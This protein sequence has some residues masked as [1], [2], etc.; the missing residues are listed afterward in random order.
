VRIGKHTHIPALMVLLLGVVTSGLHAQE[1]NSLYSYA[2]KIRGGLT[3]GDI[4]TTHFDNKVLALAAEVRREMFGPGRAL[5]L[6]LGWE[7]VPGRHHDIYPWGENPWGLTP[8]YSFDNRKEYGNGFTLRLA[9]NAPLPEF[10]SSAV[11]DVLKDIEWFGGI[12]FDRHKVRSE[13]N[14]YFNFTPNEATPAP[15]RYDGG[16]F[17]KEGGQFVPGA[18]AGLRYHFNEDLGFELS[19]R[20]F[21]MWHLDYTPSTYQYNAVPPVE[22][23]GTGTSKTGTTRGFAIEFALTLKI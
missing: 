7:Y 13:V 3:A 21:G 5:S 2:F 10:G 23:R 8:R 1:G 12:G 9:Y 22:S 18:F 11:R 20:N 14:Y 4:Q 17:V 15:G 16:T 19:V 6:E